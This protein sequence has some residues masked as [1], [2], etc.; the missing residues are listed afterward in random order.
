MGTLGI[1]L[2]FAAGLVLIFTEVLMPGIILGLMGCGCVVV[3][4]ALAFTKD[5]AFGWLLT[6]VTIACV[7]VF[8]F[9]LVKVLRKCLAIKE[10]EE[11]FSSSEIGLEQY[12]GKE[13]ISVTTLR[14]AGIAEIEGRRVDVVAHGEMIPKDT[15]IE[16]TVIKGNRVVVRAKTT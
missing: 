3:S 2:L 8:F 12:K 13:G 10:S 15:R 14:P 1:S 9:A 6:V 5:S 7:P 11:G 4:I 16:V